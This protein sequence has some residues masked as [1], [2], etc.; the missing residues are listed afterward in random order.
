MTAT[1]ESSATRRR[2]LTDW[3]NRPTKRL[4]RD[5]NKLRGKQSAEG[6]T[7]QERNDLHHIGIV[8]RE[9]DKH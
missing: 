8:L 4:M 7:D 2:T 5:Y 1:T 3:R 6:L 9:R